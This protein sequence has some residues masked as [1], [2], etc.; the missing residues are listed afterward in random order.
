MASK[1]DGNTNISETVEIPLGKQDVG[2]DVETSLDQQNVSPDVGKSTKDV[3]PNAEV[4]T[5]K[6]IKIRPTDEDKNTATKSQEVVGDSDGEQT[7]DKEENIV[8]LDDVSS[9]LNQT[10]ADTYKGNSVAKRLRSSSGK[11]VPSATAKTST[12][13]LKSVDV[14]PK[15]RWS[16]VTPKATTEKKTKKRKVVESSDSE[17][18]HVEED[19]SPIPVS[20]IKKSTGKKTSSNVSVV[21][22]DNISFHYPDYAHRWKYVFHRRL[23][24]ERELGTTVLEIKDVVD[25]IKHAGLESTVTN[26]GNCYEKLVREFL[27]NIPDDCDNPM[28]HDYHVVYVRGK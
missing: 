9:D 24:L 15:K 8:D 14:G 28:S 11:A 3:E 21:P 20:A 5:S 22:T 4:H 12:T 1:V 25:L 17:Y 2:P 10:V 23:A 18:E 7:V 13:R 26:L 6:N 19:V 27:V 16:K